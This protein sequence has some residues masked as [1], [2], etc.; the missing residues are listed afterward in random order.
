LRQAVFNIL[1]ARVQDARVLDLFAGTGAVGLEALSRGACAVT[2]VERDPRA[3]E[4]LR[5]NVAALHASDRARIISGDALP[6]LARMEAAGEPFDIIF[7]DP[8]YAGDLAGRCMERLAR[9]A[10]LSDNGMLVVQAFHKTAL[11][12]RVGV[13]A[14][15]RG[16]RYGESALT[17]YAK[18]EACR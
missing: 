9:G 6:A 10:V 4:S 13:L 5:A 12:E 7:V 11:P 8:P 1:G 15:V 17:F 2:F 18:E 16:R 14:R 3:V